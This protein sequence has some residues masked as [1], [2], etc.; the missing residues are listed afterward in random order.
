MAI[1]WILAEA[2]AFWN[3]ARLVVPAQKSITRQQALLAAVLTFVGVGIKATVLA[4]FWTIQPCGAHLP[5]G[6]RGFGF[7]VAVP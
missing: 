5:Y 2:A 3:T 6:G 4:C 7:C 1:A